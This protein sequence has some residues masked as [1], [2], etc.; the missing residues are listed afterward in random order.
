VQPDG[1]G[2]RGPP[3]P[4]GALVGGRDAA[5]RRRSGRCSPR[6]PGAVAA[7]LPT[8]PLPPQ[9]PKAAGG[10]RTK[11]FIKFGAP[12]HI[13]LLFGVVLILGSGNKWYIPLIAS[14]VFIAIVIVLPLI[15]E[16][17]LSPSQREALSAALCCG[18]GR[19]AQRYSAPRAARAVG[20]A[21]V[22]ASDG[23]RS[24]GGYGGY[25][26]MPEGAAAPAAAAPGG[27]AGAPG[28]GGGWGRRDQRRA[29]PPAQYY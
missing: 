26:A 27:G 23:S 1:H 18:R 2:E 12:F 11:D 4:Q 10:Y 15:Y 8:P 24:S 21:P 13:W 7:R 9:P 25:E 29:A 19:K 22:S 5:S 14:A 16:K 20:A 28:V 17:C 6:R 3:G